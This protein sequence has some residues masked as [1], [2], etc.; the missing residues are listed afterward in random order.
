MPRS[1]TVLPATVKTYSRATP[2]SKAISKL[3][4]VTSPAAEK[5]VKSRLILA[6]VSAVSDAALTGNSRPPSGTTTFNVPRIFN[7]PVA[8]ILA[9]EFKV[10]VVSAAPRVNDSAA[11]SSVPLAKTTSLTSSAKTGLAL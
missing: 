9:S 2:A 11:I 4:I 6:A 10:T 5:S 7:A 8:T 3:A 1:A